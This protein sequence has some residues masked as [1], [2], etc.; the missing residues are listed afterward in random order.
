MIIRARP[1]GPQKKRGVGQDSEPAGPRGLGP[2][3][4]AARTGRPTSPHKIKKKK[5]VLVYINY[6]FYGLLH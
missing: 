3:R 4:P 6:F 2:H 5:L 1:V